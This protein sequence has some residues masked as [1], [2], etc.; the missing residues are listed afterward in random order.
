MFW[1]S[2]PVF[3]LTKRKSRSHTP[4]V[5]RQRRVQASRPLPSAL[6]HWGLWGLTTRA[7]R[8][9]VGESPV[10]GVISLRPWFVLRVPRSVA[11]GG[12][13]IS[14]PQP[15]TGDPR[16][17]GLFLSSSFHLPAHPEGDSS[18]VGR[19]TSLFSVLSFHAV[20]TLSIREIGKLL[21]MAPRE[22]TK[23]IKSAHAEYQ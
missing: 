9:A 7:V 14:G 18:A 8:A 19:Q 2:F 15:D 11:R 1:S 12:S 4:V 6:P 5:P 21:E 16:S 3:W 17:R 13:P 20:S 10:A 23:R 22:I